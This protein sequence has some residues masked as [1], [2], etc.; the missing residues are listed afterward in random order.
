MKLPLFERHLPLLERPVHLLGRVVGLAPRRAL[1]RSAALIATVGLSLQAL[2][3]FAEG[4]IRIARQFGIVYLLLDVAREQN[5]IEKHAKAAGVDAKVEWIQLSG[6]SAVNDALLSGSIDIAGA[7]IAPLLTLWDRTRGRQDVR[8]V[9]SL[10]NFP[11]YLVTNKPGVGSIA[12]FGDRD[13]I[14]VPA[15]GVSIQSRFLQIASA[16]LWG[17]DQYAKLDRISVALPHPEA[18]AAIIKGGTEITGHF[19]NP[20]FQEQELAA[21]PQ[22]RIVLDSYD[23][24]GGPSSPTVLYAL[25]KYRKGNPKTYGAFV[26]ALNEAALFIKD[27]PDEAAD[28]FLKANGGKGDRKPIL[29]VI[30]NPRVEFK[31]APEKT[32]V[33]ADFM[34][35][36]GAIRNKPVSVRDY[37]FDDVLLDAGS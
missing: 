12:D 34:H 33:L 30:R 26:A 37:F 8:G 4:Q 6:G 9:A 28:I 16:R 10:G 21:T 22:A 23:V 17:D 11:Y 15:V 35:R 13:R 14:A 25:D 36:V 5:L 2:P 32:Q 20:P 18:A 3:A 27:R 1:L 24:L 29:E 7:G 19:A 31:T